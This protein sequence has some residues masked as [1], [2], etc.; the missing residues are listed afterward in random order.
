MPSDKA[1]KRSGDREGETRKAE[2]ER[3]KKEKEACNHV[4]REKNGEEENEKEG[5]NE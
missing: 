1:L 3:K 5:K 4:L 2:E